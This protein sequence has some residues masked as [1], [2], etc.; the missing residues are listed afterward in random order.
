[1]TEKTIG[2]ITFHAAE[3][4]GSALQAYALQK[5]LLGYGYDA[6]IIDFILD[7]DME[8]Y[9]IFRTYLYSKHPKNIIKD[10][11]HFKYIIK[12]KYNFNK[13]KQS[14]LKIS[15]KTYHAGIDDLIEL[16]NIYDCFICGSDQIWNLNCTGGMI[17]E[18]FL[19]FVDDSK[20]KIAYAPSMP[21]Q[22]HPK[23]H[24]VVKNAIERL[25]YISVRERSTVGYLK[26]SLKIEKPISKVI[27]P[28][29]LLN[30]DDYINDFNL[31]K[32]E[33]KYIFVYL[34]YDDNRNQME[35]VVNLAL[36]LSK[37]EN[38]GIKYVYMN[39]IKNFKSGDFLLGIGPKEFLD[40]I[41]NASYVIT[42]SFHATVFSILFKKRF[43]VVQRM[44]S[45]S[46]MVELLKEL[47]LENNLYDSDN[48]NWMCSFAS[49]A[50]YEVLD[51]EKRL[52]LKYLIDSLT[53]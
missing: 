1:M 44:G 45:Q 39:K 17:P 40:M 2:I 6:Q 21:G 11:I 3:N 10:I 32:N 20:R 42:N 27:D 25:N 51:E 26:D 7:S 8:Q 53:A 9:K 16:N 13:F 15:K 12:R 37:S 24:E 43:C 33:E 47:N 41:F 5:V 14:Y 52:S 28:T 19:S 48:F 23:Y 22:I 29:L 38:I 4:F 34:L 35:K 31:E 30:A 46:R 18:F 49:K 36:E 50:N